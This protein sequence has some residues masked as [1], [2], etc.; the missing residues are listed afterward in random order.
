MGFGR[1]QNKNK[2]PSLFKKEKSKALKCRVDE[3]VVGKI[4]S[5]MYDSQ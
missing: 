3:G 2:P 5:E 4:V 1:R